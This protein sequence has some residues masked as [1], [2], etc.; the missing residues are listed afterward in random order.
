VRRTLK[1]TGI[2]GLSTLTCMETRCQLP[3]ERIG[4]V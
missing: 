1:R 3:D 4:G 2:S